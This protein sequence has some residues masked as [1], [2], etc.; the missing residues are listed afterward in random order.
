MTRLDRFKEFARSNM[1]EVEAILSEVY[2]ARCAGRTSFALFDGGAHKGYH[3]LRMLGLPGCERV[4]A[5]EADPFMAETFTSIVQRSRPNDLHRLVFHQKALQGDPDRQSIPW[6]S[7]PTHVG[8]SSIV[9]HNATR[10]TIWAD[11]ADMR[12]R[13]ELEVPCTTIDSILA[14][15]SLSVPFVKLDLEGA[16]LIALRGAAA[17]L[18][19]KRPVVAFENSLKAPAVHGF[20]IEEMAAFFRGLNYVP[21]DFSGSRMAPDTWFGFFEAWLAPEEDAA[22]LTEQLTSALDRRGL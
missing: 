1:M 6:R 8:R 16:D 18:R 20:T 11:N 14:L 4:H 10:P 15:E 5:V 3:T 22:W 7:S 9:S 12:Y 2:S 17:T 13:D 19:D 21:M